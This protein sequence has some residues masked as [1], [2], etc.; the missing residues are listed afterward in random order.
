[1]A[2]AKEVNEMLKANMFSFAE[3]LFPEGK[4]HG[5]HYLI[6]GV[7]GSRGDSM[8]IDIEGPNTGAYIDNNPSGGCR[9]GSPI[10]LYMQAKGIEFLAAYEECKEWLEARGV[11]AAK[12]IRAKASP[13]KAKEKT[14]IQKDWIE[15]APNTKA[16]DYLTDER[17]LTPQVLKAYRVGSGSIWFR[18]TEKKVSSIVFP[19]YA[20]E[21][22]GGD[23]LMA[24][25]LAIERPEGRKITRSNKA[26]VYHLIGWQAGPPPGSDKRAGTLVIT[27]G[28]IDAMTM[29]ML[30]YCA[31]SVPFG[32]KDT[33]RGNAWIE[34]DWNRLDAFDDIVLMLDNDP[35]GETA[36]DDILQRLGKERCRVVEWPKEIKDANQGLTDYPEL[37][38]GLIE[39][40]RAFDPEELKRAREFEQAVYEEFY[41]PNG[42]LPGQPL[43]WKS[44]T[45]PFRI[46]EGE[47]TCWTG[48][49]G[50]GKT[51]AM[52]YVMTWLAHLGERVCVGSFEL[53]ARKTLRNVL[54]QG[55]GRKKPEIH[56]EFNDP[57][58]RRSCDWMDDRFFIYDKV[59]Q[60][61]LDDVLRVFAYCARRYA[62]GQFV[63]DSIMCLDVV[64]D[65]HEGQKQ[66]M[67]SLEA[68]AKEYLVHVHVVAHS[69]KGTDKRPEEKYWPRKHDVNGSVHLTNLPDN[70][71]CIYRNLKK[72]QEIAALELKRQTATDSD[73]IDA[74]I[75]A[76]EKWSD[77]LFIVLKQRETGE[78]PVLNLWFDGSWGGGSWQFFDTYGES[79][80][81]LVTTKN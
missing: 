55:M 36:R 27:E 53:P 6:G 41:P 11:L 47:V 73:D 61:K 76:R 26:P 18:E 66:M 19:A 77:A 33:A 81:D 78:L 59:G 29:W 48:Y 75:D 51:V 50:H 54:K 58:W 3:W 24:K 74:D 57:L 43:P 65:D 15:I 9:P 64:E 20:T 68:F 63:I 80:R 38:D 44:D 31:V 2:N 45:F 23:L 28:E 60:A 1:M 32:A 71:V 8:V 72:E 69:K 67:Q 62:I 39:N 21:E 7:D 37:M 46:R 40:A 5:R 70:V 25:Y 42:E 10:D 49:S 16:F 52:T 35:A 14:G 56:G 30:G 17:G 4:R 34:H 13:P 79:P 22:E 12:M